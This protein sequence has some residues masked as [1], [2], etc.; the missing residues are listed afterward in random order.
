MTSGSSLALGH[1]GSK[2]FLFFAYSSRVESW[3]SDRKLYLQLP[4]QLHLKLHPGSL[5]LRPAGLLDSPKEPL[6]GNLVLQVTL[7]TSLQLRA[8]LPN[9][10]GRTL[11][12]KSYVLRGIPYKELGQIIFWIEDYRLK[13]MLAICSA[14]KVSL[15]P[16]LL[17]GISNFL[18]LGL[19]LIWKGTY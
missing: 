2:L 1:P 9:S 12:D 16:R 6:S 3:P 8:E 15:Q 19:I 10:H 18:V 4:P 11:T 14:S 5:A 17:Q 13:F 7:H